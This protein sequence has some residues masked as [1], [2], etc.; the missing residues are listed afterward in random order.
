MYMPTTIP[1]ISINIASKFLQYQDK[2]IKTIYEV[3]KVFGKA[4]RA[5]T[6]T[7]PAPLSMIETII[8]LKPKTQWRK[9]I[10]YEDIINELDSKLQIKGVVNG[11]TQPI[12][13]RIDMIS[14][15]I[16]TPL[17][18][19]LYSDNLKNLIPTSIEIE[20]E[21]KK[22]NEFLTVYADRPSSNPY[23][24]INYNRDKLFQYNLNINDI[25]QYFDYLFSNKPITITIDRIKRYK[26]SLGID[27]NYKLNLLNTPIYVK[28]KLIK[29]SD[30]CDIEY[31]ESFS[32][33]KFENGFYVNYIFLVPKEGIDLNLTIKKIDQILKQVINKKEGVFFYEYTGDFKYWLSTINNLKLILP[34]VFIIIFLLVYITFNDIKDVI[35]FFYLLPSSLIGSVMIM[36]YLGYSLSV[37]S[38]AGIVATLGIAVEMLIIMIIN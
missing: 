37:A 28:G 14:T 16:R 9:N 5:N 2:I 26:V 7:D 22:R 6:A 30:V 8:T 31:L 38:I 36:K 21:L 35:L 23:L 4:G 20:K 33:I 18:I 24:I 25:Q 11:W 3:D 19:K 29:L 17:G 34:L 32:E 15:G 12:K 13:G 1:A 10:T 27:E